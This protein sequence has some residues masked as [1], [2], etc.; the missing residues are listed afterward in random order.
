[1]QGVNVEQPVQ[2]TRPLI[3]VTGATGFIG[4]RIVSELPKRSYRVR[5]LLRRHTDMDFDCASAVVGDL[6]HPQ[7]LSAALADVDAVVHSAGVAHAMSGVPEADYRLLNTEATVALA[8]AAHRARVKRFVFLSSIRAQSGPSSP[9][10]LS[11]QMP[12]APTDAYGRSKLAA[13]QGLAEVGIDWT[14]LRPVLVFGPGVRGNFARL[15][16]IAKSP[17]PL[18]IGGLNA[19]RSLLSVDSLVDAVDAVLRAPGEL[20]R[21]LIVADAEP[22]TVGEMI[23]ALRRGLGRGPHIMPVPAP[24]LH[25][26]LK[27]ASRQE[28]SGRLAESLVADASALTHIGWQP[29]S[30]TADDLTALMRERAAP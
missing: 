14:A 19:R 9:V 3:A 26:A 13:E 29:R 6:A 1:M 10:V 20:R 8:R 4:R 11:E 24:L 22:L 18:P 15:I 25:L 30:S 7:N 12:P 21:P 27:L 17:Y 23:A 28:W 2:S 16:D 5:V